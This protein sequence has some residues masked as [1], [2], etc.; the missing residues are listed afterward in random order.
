[1]F[2]KYLIKISLVLLVPL[3]LSGCGVSKPVANNTVNTTPTINVPTDKIENLAKA[4]TNAGV[5]MYGASRCSHCQ[6][7]KAAFGDAWQFVTYV[8]CD[9]PAHPDR[10]TEACVSANI[11]LYPTWVFGDNSRLWGVQSFETL[12]KKAGLTF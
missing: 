6:S 7:Q 10:Q 3:L 2:A 4:L 5:K 9:D 1:M 8:E 11:E 12:A